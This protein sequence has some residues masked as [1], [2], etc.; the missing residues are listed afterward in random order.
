MV[1]RILMELLVFIKG[2]LSV[3]VSYHE[4]LGDNLVT[5][6]TRHEAHY[7]SVEADSCYNYI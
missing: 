7:R 2:I 6:S 4:D 3:L 5:D 1:K